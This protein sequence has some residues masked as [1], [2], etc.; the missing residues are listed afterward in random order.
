MFG[1][2]I[3]IVFFLMLPGF[4]R[5]LYRAWIIF[6]GSPKAQIALRIKMKNA[7]NHRKKYGF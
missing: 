1:A 6:F 3:F 5:F 4:F 7:Q 2:L